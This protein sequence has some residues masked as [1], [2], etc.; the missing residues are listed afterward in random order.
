MIEFVIVAMPL[1]L[2]GLAAVELGRW[3]LVR[4]AVGY[5]LFEAARTGSVSGARPL[6]ITQ[7]FQRALSPLYGAASPVMHGANGSGASGPGRPDTGTTF[8]QAQADVTRALVQFE[9]DYGQPRARLEMLSPATASFDDFADAA[10]Q[11]RMGIAKRV[12]NNTYQAEKNGADYARRY[13]AGAGPRSG[14]TIHDANVLR[15]RLTY[16]QPPMLPG[17]RALLANLP[18]R[19]PGP[20]LYVQRAHAQGLLVIAREISIPMQSDA[21]EYLDRGQTILP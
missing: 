2:T 4:Q 14:Q 10:L 18:A 17:L 3:Y 15:L 6:A 5:A 1:L 9:R 7:A 13:R 8:L 20:D 19:G 21:V 11:R 16:L 12:I